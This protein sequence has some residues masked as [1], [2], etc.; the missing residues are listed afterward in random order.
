MTDTH[1]TK[2]EVLAAIIEKGALPVLESASKEMQND[3]DVVLVAAQGNGF[4]LQYASHAIR[5]TDEKVGLAA[6]NSSGVMALQFLYQPV[7]L[8][9]LEKYLTTCRSMGA[10]W[11]KNQIN[12]LH[13]M[14]GSL[15]NLDVKEIMAV[16]AKVFKNEKDATSDF[17][18]AL[19]K[20]KGV[21][22]DPASPIIS[23][24]A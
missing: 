9:A 5:S 18:T 20:I 6:L 17:K 2:V 3:P 10:D 1:S 21:E 8:P 12:D 22:D 15:Q 14:D 4:A 23:P 19:E 24:S 16:V 11:V 7:A 13:A